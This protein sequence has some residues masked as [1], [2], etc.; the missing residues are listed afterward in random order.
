MHLG[1]S[2]TVFQA[3]VL[4]IFFAA[5]TL[6]E[7]NT[8]NRS[9]CFY[10]DSQAAIN[11]LISL[12]IYTPSVRDCIRALN[13]LGLRNS[14]RVLW[15]PGHSGHRGNEVADS[16]ARS[17]TLLR[18]LGPRPIIPLPWAE[19]NQ[20]LNK[21]IAKLHAKR[22]DAI[23]GCRQTKHAIIS[24]SLHLR[25]R[26]LSLPRVHLR[27][28]MMVISGHGLFTRHRYIQGQAASSVCGFCH[29]GPEDAFHYVCFCPYFLRARNRHIGYI[30]HM[31]TLLGKDCFYNLLNYIK[32]TERFAPP[33]T[34]ADPPWVVPPLL[35]RL[36][37]P[38]G[39][40]EWDPWS[41][42]LCVGRPAASSSSSF[43]YGSIFI[44]SNLYQIGL[45]LKQF[46]K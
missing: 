39:F 15:I 1:C 2:A 22:W 40:G 9:I 3:E 20:L 29:S 36:S 16:L 43:L 13:E 46:L 5:K 10:S 32:D 42:F 37:S 6:L 35:P 11:A 38:Q 26:L 4:A 34:A 33:A 7:N 24:P 17:G 12:R 41:S 14:V 28:M 25:K 8:R 21:W 31:P 18:V 30:T 19:V 45:Y 44:V 27:S 23:D